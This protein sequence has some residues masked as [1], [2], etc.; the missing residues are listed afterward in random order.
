MLSVTGIKTIAKQFL[1]AL[2]VERVYHAPDIF[3][4]REAGR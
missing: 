4:D 1:C 2:L 3:I